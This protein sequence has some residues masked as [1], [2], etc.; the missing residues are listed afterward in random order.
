MYKLVNHR[1]E[2]IPL[3]NGTV[4]PADSTL[5]DVPASVVFH[6]SNSAVLQGL[7]RSRKV[8]LIEPP[9]GVVKEPERGEAVQINEEIMAMTREELKEELEGHGL[10]PDDFKFKPTPQLQEMLQKVKYVDL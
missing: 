8:S 9:L 1:P 3:P 7:Y 10:E 4:I 6:P 2:D 5:E